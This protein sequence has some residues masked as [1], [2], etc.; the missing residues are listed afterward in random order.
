MVMWESH[1]RVDYVSVSTGHVFLAV[2]R[3]LCWLLR[4]TNCYKITQILFITGV[5][6]SGIS[7]E[8]EPSARLTGRSPDPSGVV[9]AAVVVVVG[10]GVVVVVDVDVVDVVVVVEVASPSVV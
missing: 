4:C 8:D 7:R 10:V 5:K 1:L 3:T 6:L 2:M 9:V